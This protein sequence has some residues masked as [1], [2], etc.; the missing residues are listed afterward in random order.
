M[1]EPNPN[2]FLPGRAAAPMPLDRYLPPPA[3]GEAGPWCQAHVP[4]GAWVLEP[5]GTSPL[6]ALEAARAGYRVVVAAGNPVAVFLMEF[7]A[8]APRAES[9]PRPPADRG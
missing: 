7:C 6:L 1:P 2:V 8:S 4:A 3:G 9:P 5:F